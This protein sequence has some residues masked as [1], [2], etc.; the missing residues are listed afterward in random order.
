MAENDVENLRKAMEPLGFE[1]IYKYNLTKRE[2]EGVVDDL[3]KPVCL[4]VLA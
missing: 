2:I 4:F 1:V 3:C